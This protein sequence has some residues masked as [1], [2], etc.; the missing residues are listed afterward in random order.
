MI[1][2]ADLADGKPIESASPNEQRPHLLGDISVEG[3]APAASETAGELILNGLLL[4]GNVKVLT[5]NLGTLRLSHCTIVPGIGKLSVNG[6]NDEPIIRVEHSICG[7]ID[8]PDSVTQLF[9]QD[10]IVDGFGAAAVVAKG[11]RADL[12]ASTFFGDVDAKMLEA[13]NS[14]FMD[15]LTAKLRQAGCVRFCFLRDDSVTPRRYRCQPDLAL[16]DITDAA[17]QQ[18]IR[19]RIKPSFTSRDYGQPGYAQ[20]KLT[21]PAEITSGA[22]DGAEMGVFYFLKQPQREVNLLASLDEYLRF[23]LEA[24]IFYVT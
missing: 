4:E 6:A 11:S 18:S 22:D 2:A 3:T 21:V 23:G 20:L 17:A 9:V 7:M 15:K 16:Q 24:G 19:A 12:Q 10:S 13:G 8:L 1:Y 14:I 5:G